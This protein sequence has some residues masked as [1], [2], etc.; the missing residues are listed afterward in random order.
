MK[1]KN[2]YGEMGVVRFKALYLPV[3]TSE[4]TQIEGDYK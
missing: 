3:G 4:P 1:N 2:K